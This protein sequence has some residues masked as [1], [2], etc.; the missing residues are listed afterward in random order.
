MG[1]VYDVSANKRTYGP[2]GSY[3]FFTGADGSRA[4]VTGCFKYHI[5]HDLR[6]FDDEQMA[7]LQ[8]WHDFFEKSD[9]YPKVGT[10]DLPPIDPDSELPTNKC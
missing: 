2:G 9:K 8:G 10:V 6:G 5:T 4:Y 3:N 1:D 7:S